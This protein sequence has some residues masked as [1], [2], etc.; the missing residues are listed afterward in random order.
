MRAFETLNSLY[1]SVTYEFT[2]RWLWPW[3]QFRP[4]FNP[5]PP[6]LGELLL[7]LSPRYIQ[8]TQTSQKEGWNVNPRRIACFEDLC[9]WF[10][11]WCSDSDRIV[12]HGVLLR[13]G[14]YEFVQELVWN[15]DFFFLAGLR[16]SWMWWNVESFAT[17]VYMSLP[18]RNIFPLI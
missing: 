2:T 18:E 10:S 7:E 13:S 1:R 14:V 4:E 17:S 3:S 5:P 9:C 6:F 12:N 8:L 16:H 11:S 15:G